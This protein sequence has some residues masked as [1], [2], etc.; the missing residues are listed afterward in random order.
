MASAGPPPL[1]GA[2]D[3]LERAVGY[4]RVSLRL[5]P[6]NGMG[7]PTP[8]PAWHLRD[9]LHHMDDSLTALQEAADLGAVAATPSI[10][11][12]SQD[13]VTTLRVRACTLLGAWTQDGG[14]TLVSVAGCPVTPSLLLG[15]GAL[16]IAVH[17][18][19][20]A[21]ACDGP[22]PLPRALSE[23]LLELAPLLVSPDDRPTRFAPPVHVGL[24][25]PP[26]DRLLAFLGRA[27]QP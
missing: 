5:V 13:I 25:A 24:L 3:L 15:T 22:R 9:L 6:Q 23:E 20:V 7:R 11:D 17:G 1:T 2:L 18:W 8:C 4:A 21:R 10:D 12:P 19:D 16:E 26:G 27:P 14:T